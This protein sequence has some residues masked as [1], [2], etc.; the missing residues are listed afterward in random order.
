MDRT[1]SFL[2]AEGEI[3]ARLRAM[4]WSRSPLGPP[5]GWPHALRTV[6]ALMLASKFPMFVA[7]GRELTF[8]YNDAYTDILGH[9]H[10]WALG[11]RFSDV[12]AEIW[13]EL[14]PMVER[15]LDGEATYQED[16]PFTMWRKGYAEPTWFT[17]SYSRVFGDDGEVAGMYCACT[18]TTEA[19]LARGQHQRQL[20]RLRTLFQQ[21]P[22][23]IAVLRGPDHVFELANEAYQQLVG[24]RDLIGR[25]VTQA[26]PEVTGQ[27]FID[28]LDKVYESGEPFI[29]RA[30]PVRLKRQ[31]GAEPQME[32]RF[33]DFIYQ[34]IRDEDGRV[35]GIFV[36]GS[37]V[38]EAMQAMAALRESE[39]RLLQLANTIQ[40]LAWMATPDGVPA[41][42]NDRWYAYTGTTPEQMREHG[43][44]HLVH[45]DDLPAEV[46]RWDVSMRTGQPYE[47]EMRLRGADGRYRLFH[48]TAAPVRD[49][50]GRIVQ[51]FGTNTDVSEERAAQEAL[52]DANRRKDEFLAMLAHELR[53]PLAP[54]STAAHLLRA[55]AHEDPRARRA[56]EIIIRQV[57]HMVA[58]VDDLLDVSR[59]TRGLVELKPEPVDIGQ[60][61]AD[62][63]EQVRPLLE[64]RAH[65]L[66]VTLP[67]PPPPLVADRTR[68]T[69]VVANLLHNAAKY[70]PPR[71]RVALRA[72]VDDGRLHL[73]VE[74]NGSG[75]DGELLPQVFTLFAQASRTP[76]RAQGGLGIGLALVRGLVELH[77]GSVE[78]HSDGPGRGARFTVSLPLAA[79]SLPLAHAALPAPPRPTRTTHRVM[80][81]DDNLDA[82]NVLADFL[83]QQGY[84]VTVHDDPGAALAEAGAHPQDAILL[85]IGMPGMDGYELARRLRAGG[86]S[87]DALLIAL[88]GYGQHQDRANSRAAGFDAHLVKPA[89]PQRL[90]GLLGCGRAVARAG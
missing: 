36:E 62:A 21:A 69:Q 16:L 27:G 40:H 80:V 39:Q 63:I 87:R 60:V 72:M 49:A 86:A 68:L 77:G 53:N 58:L 76:D 23:V 56:S 65:A 75:I 67:T 59:V 70:T 50:A 42:F 9:K 38:T 13:M 8:L 29:G 79:P 28:L 89:E 90:L 85:D 17:F 14:A 34:P 44:A 41:W 66:A 55:I 74:D 57:Q 37:D 84:T 10:P 2:E 61:V 6:V 73:A 54:I 12:W 33:V 25:P 47:G 20:E 24:T 31:R 3:A 78:A 22:G 7:W 30:V 32:E 43:W 11:Q 18:E 46:A 5:A 4:D 82:A 26:L 64:A 1:L 88:T 35:T 51:W 71:G 19:V 52:R 48:G 81:V 15:A 83:R 45:P